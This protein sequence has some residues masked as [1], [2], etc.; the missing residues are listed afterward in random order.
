MNVLLTSLNS[1][2]IHQNLA[3]RLLYELN[4][5]VANLQVREFTIKTDIEEIAQYCTQYQLVAL[6]CYIW[7]ITKT[8]QVAA[9]I[10][11]LNPLCLIMLGGPEVS[12][13]WEDVI[14][15]DSIDFIVLDEGEIP[16]AA[17]LKAF[18]DL[19]KVP[20]LVWKRDGEVI[21][22]KQAELFDLNE[23]THVN[24]YASIPDEE[25]RHKIS[26]IEAS[27]GC[28]HRCE[29]CL[30]GLQNKM[31]YLPLEALKRNLLYVMERGKTI[32]FLDRTFN[33][34]PQFAISIFQFILDHYQPE[35][36]F[37]FEIKADVIQPEL[38]TFIKEH[39]P[40]GIFRFEIGIQT[41]NVQSNRDINRKLDF[42]NIKYFISQVSDNVE[43]HVDLIVGLP[44]DYW[45]DIKYS[46]EEVFKLY[47]PELQLGFLK[48]L[49]GTPI[50]NDSQQHDYR[51]E[52][53]PPYQLIGSKYLSEN[54]L[55]QISYLEE[56]LDIYW[57]KKRAINTLK[58]V[59][60]N[61]SIFDFLLG[62]GSYFKN[63]NN[64]KKV[65]LAEV[66]TVISEYVTQNS[67]QNRVLLDL[68]ATDY[69]LQHKIKPQSRFLP[70]PAH[71]EKLK[72][73]ELYGLN[74]QQFRYVIHPINF[75][76]KRWLDDAIFEPVNDWLIVEYNGVQQP[77]LIL[78]RKQ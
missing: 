9:R 57:N 1:K 19:D 60:A 48:F 61:S 51:F 58:Y 8:L 20:G 35:N 32:K 76:L 26:Y 71:D 74:T 43:T 73:C 62:L 29:Y 12:F 59:A 38:I 49:K 56:V 70:E 72:I 24:P 28:P 37:Q 4:K 47:A 52:T 65:E 34:N 46:F 50:R 41:L 7:N 45:N 25:L 53:E 31:R 54:E 75:S 64:F 3:I 55:E 33:A 6:S 2:Y 69:Y 42:D 36:L 22:N 27:R 78:K 30:A 39:V 68:I 18:P 23:L 10:K 67:P 21:E 77:K 63:K 5:D 15:K 14:S 17:F 40:K 11:Q 66:Y 16:F 44:N 13:E